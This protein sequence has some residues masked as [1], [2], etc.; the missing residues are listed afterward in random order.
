MAEGSILGHT[1][2]LAICTCRV[3][4]SYSKNSFCIRHLR[5]SPKDALNTVLFPYDLVENTIMFHLMT[6]IHP[7]KCIIGQFHHMNIIQCTYTNQDG[8]VYYV[9][10]L[11]G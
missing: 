2:K 11:Y 10:R 6:G 4:V 1:D 8:I 3:R 7:E 9:P 5:D